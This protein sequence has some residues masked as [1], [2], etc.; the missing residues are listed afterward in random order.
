MAVWVWSGGQC[1]PWER[2]SG[3]CPGVS[4]WTGREASRG[5]GELAEEWGPRWALGLLRDVWDET[6]LPLGCLAFLCCGAGL[7]HGAWQRPVRWFPWGLKTSSLEFCLGLSLSPRQALC[8]R[9][10]TSPHSDTRAHAFLPCKH[11]NIHSRTRGHYIFTANL[12]GQ[13]YPLLFTH[14]WTHMP[15]RTHVF[16]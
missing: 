5:L 2:G 16:T 7:P 4:G 11:V 10:F 9:P 8:P 13:T 6:H 14:W 15:T 3:W 12:C 1:G